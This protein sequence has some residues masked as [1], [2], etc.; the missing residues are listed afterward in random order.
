MKLLRKILYPFSVLYGVITSVRNYLYNKNILKA[1]EFNIPTIVVGNLSIGGTGKTPQIEYL[2]RLLQNDYKVAVLSRG[3]KRKSKGFIIANENASAE[4]IG[5]EPFQYYQKF[6]DIIVCVDADRT[7]AIQQLQE[8]VNPP[9]LILL[10][11]AFQHRKVAGGF[12]IL[13]TPYNDLYV[14]DT[15]LPTGNLREKVSGAGRANLIIVTKCPETLSEDEQFEITKKLNPSLYQT[16]FFT[17]IDYENE[18][19]GTL[20]VNLSELESAEVLLITGIAKPKPLLK[21]LKEK[22]I[23]FE[24]LKYPD[25]Y[26]FNSKDIGEINKRFELLKT[27]NKILLTTEKDYVRIF[28]KFKNLN[29]ISIKTK[30]INH[31][32]DFDNII[33]NY[34]EQSSR[35]S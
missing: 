17:T 32:N 30:F 22:N 31:K 14:N 21:Y 10:D 24:H 20:K 33:K 26:H 7:N 4:L 29:Y 19:Q 28:D 25:H 12:N 11:D 5:D 23:K 27:N 8:L 15:M 34:V 16:V 35:N 18:L 3:Y 1:T 6:K 9:Q 2:I 13:L